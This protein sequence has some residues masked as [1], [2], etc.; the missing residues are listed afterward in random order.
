MSPSDGPLK[1]VAL[2]NED[3]TVVAAHLQDAVGVIGD[4]AYVPR[5][6]RFVALLNRFDWTSV[7]TEGAGDGQRRRAA[8][9]IE[10]V[11][12]AQVQGIDLSHK[13][14]VVAVLT[15]QFEPEGD[16]AETPG[17]T[18]TLLLAGGGAI[19]LHVECVEVVV[20][21][22]GPVWAARASPQH[23]VNSET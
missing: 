10:R 12:K 18:L 15:M 20:E 1:L 21:D 8:L 14:E 23:D 3:L 7:L 13:G 5:D 19:R 22:L 4:L 2:D 9:R 16:P 17:G 11:L 6:R